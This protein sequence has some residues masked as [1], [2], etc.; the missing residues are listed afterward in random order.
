LASLET[1]WQGDHRGGEE[2]ERRDDREDH[3]GFEDAT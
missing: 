1:T 2:S 3:F